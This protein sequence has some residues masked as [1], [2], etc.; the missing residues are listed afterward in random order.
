ML[1]SVK[2]KIDAAVVGLLK[3]IQSDVLPFLLQCTYLQALPTTFVGTVVRTLPGV[4]MTS[5]ASSS[6]RW[7]SAM[8]R[9]LFEE[10]LKGVCILGQ[11]FFFKTSNLSFASS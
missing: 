7:S 5:G 1:I 4:D 2:P 9:T 3:R 6:L 10:L 8:P 11:M